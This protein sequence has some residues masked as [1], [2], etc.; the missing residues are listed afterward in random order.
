VG[1]IVLGAVVALMPIM[2]VDAEASSGSPLKKA[3]EFSKEKITGV[4]SITI[5]NQVGD[6]IE[7]DDVKKTKQAEEKQQK[8]KKIPRGVTNLSEVEKAVEFASEKT[9][10]RKDFIMG[11]LVVESDLGRNPGKCTYGEVEADA[12]RSHKNGQLSET[13]W[14]TF[15]ERKNLVKSIADGLGYDYEKL[16]VS[17]NPASYAGTGGAMGIPQFMPDTW[18]EYKDRVAAVVGKENPDPWNVLDGVT[19][20]ALKVADVPGVVEHNQWSE[21]AASKLY[22]SGTTSWR[23]DWYASEIQYWANNYAKLIG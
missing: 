3:I 12:E 17:C 16:R 10:V 11:M 20:M 2:T 6:Q 8:K 13:A 14:N 7:Q 1:A 19:A 15:Q 23:Y 5:D 21:R 9:G 18:F 22:L 4:K